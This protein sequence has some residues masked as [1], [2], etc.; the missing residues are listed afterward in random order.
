MVFSLL[1]KV[2]QQV[3]GAQWCVLQCCVSFKDTVMGIKH[4]P[5]CGLRPVR[6]L[7]V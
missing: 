6:L 2:D 1:E 5:K 7:A 4:E 3:T